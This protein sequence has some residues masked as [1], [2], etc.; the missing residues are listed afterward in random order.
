MGPVLPLLAVVGALAVVLALLTALAG[1]V[2]R[3]GTAGGGLRG[4][5]AAHDEAYHGTAA[6]SYYEIQVQTDRRA[7]LPDDRWKRG[8]RP[9]RRA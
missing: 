8:P 6:D 3:R 5:L 9:G 1:H 4:A 2:R 7:P